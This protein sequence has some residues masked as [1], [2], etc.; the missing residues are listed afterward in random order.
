M[1]NSIERKAWE[2]VANRDLQALKQTIVQLADV[3]FSDM[4][5]NLL[6]LCVSEREFSQEIANFLVGKGLNL[7]L[8]ADI[9]DGYGSDITYH[10]APICFMVYQNDTDA[11]LFLK[12]IQNERVNLNLVFTEAEINPNDAVKESILPF[13]DQCFQ[14]EDATLLHYLVAY[15]DVEKVRALL[16]TGRVN[17]DAQA[18]LWENRHLMSWDSFYE[19]DTPKGD[20]IGFKDCV[21]GPKEVRKISGVTALHLAA[22]R[23][24]L[25]MVKLLQSHAAKFNVKDS[26]KRSLSA[27]LAEA[28]FDKGVSVPDAELSYM[29]RKLARKRYKK[30]LLL[31]EANFSF[32]A[33]MLDKHQGQQNLGQHVVAT[34]YNSEL[35]VNSRYPDYQ[36]KRQQLFFHQCNPIFQVDA[37]AFNRHQMVGQS[38]YKVIQFNCPHDGSHYDQQ[39]I[40]QM[41]QRFFRQAADNQKNGDRVQMALPDPDNSKGRAWYHGYVYH[42]V[43]VSALAGYQLQFKRPFNQKRFP[44]YQHQMTRQAGSAGGAQRLSEFVFEKTEMNYQAILST[45]KLCSE[46]IH[47]VKC[48]WVDNVPDQNKK[49]SKA[50]YDSYTEVEPTYISSFSH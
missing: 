27:Y 40:H 49:D 37:R 8:Q 20:I 32:A 13:G 42:L 50:S 44:G 9:D 25:V 33:A 48:Y 15:G 14:L 7:N 4:G 3:N 18:T 11:N 28:S 39:T 24:D 5:F 43:E 19:Y 17:I 6:A 35:V 29:E 45:Y 10:N 30:R 1:L 12:L 2:A 34:E 23:G 31:G 21:H 46:V 16:T 26:Q 41:L 36:T 47:G 38:R 22:R